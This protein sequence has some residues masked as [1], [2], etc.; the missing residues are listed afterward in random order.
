MKPYTMSK[1][2][3]VNDL[4]RDVMIA[5]D[6]SEIERMNIIWYTLSDNQQ[7]Q[8]KKISPEFFYCILSVMDT[9]K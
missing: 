3:N 2:A 9:I 4:I 7:E 8:I 5:Q 6:I 1:Y